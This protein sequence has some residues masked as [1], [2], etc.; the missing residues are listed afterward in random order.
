MDLKEN[1]NIDTI[2]Y[3]KEIVKKVTSDFIRIYKIIPLQKNSNG[4]L[5]AI[6]DK[7][8]VNAI[9]KIRALLE[10][11]IIIFEAPNEKI[12]KINSIVNSK[13]EDIDFKK[14]IKE[15]FPNVYTNIDFNNAPVVKMFESILTEGTS[16]NAS[17][18]H[19][20]SLENEIRIRFRVDGVLINFMKIDKEIK[21]ALSARIKVLCN[22]N[23]TENRLPQDGRM[24]KIINDI[25]YDFRVSILPSVYGEKIVIRILD[26]KS[27]TFSIDKIGLDKERQT[28]L[29]ELLKKESGIILVTGPTGCGKSTTLYSFLEELNNEEVNVMTVEDPVEYSLYGITQIQVNE[30]IGFTFSSI[31]RSILRQDPNVI[32]I[33]EIRDEVTA[34]IAMR[35]AITGHLV[36]STLH[37]ND[38]IGAITRLTNLG[39]E[40]FLIANSLRAVISQRL[41][42]K[43]CDKCKE[44]HLTT[45]K[46]MQLLDLSEK[47]IIYQKKGCPICHNTGYLGRVGVYEILIINEEIKNLLYKDSDYTKIKAKAIKTIEKNLMTDAREK[48]LNGIT[49]I[50][51]YFKICSKEYN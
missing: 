5:C 46:E 29:I 40:P 36:L 9:D 26:S 20:E 10:D 33:G 50:D 21:E 49:S 51:E 45:T 17:D 34:S 18:I 7:N 2:N 1:I 19:I 6:S 42:R 14:D 3:E 11:E 22:L 15:T 43:L 28:K 47:K 8:D 38:S 31:L 41:V 4:Y 25:E 12:Q 13:I 24:K 35:L 37:T 16:R 27:F 30:K 23:V 48:V 39:I 32:M 44:E